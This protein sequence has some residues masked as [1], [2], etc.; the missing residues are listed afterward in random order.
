MGAGLTA[1]LV[2]RADYF[3]GFP[4]PLILPVGAI[5]ARQIR[6]MASYMPRLSQNKGNGDVLFLFMRIEPD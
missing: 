6:L 5:G 4:F 1:M 2:S 3:G